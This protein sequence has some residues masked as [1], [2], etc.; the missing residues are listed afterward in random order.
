MRAP[1]RPPPEAA[2]PSRGRLISSTKEMPNVEQLAGDF[3][4]IRGDFRIAGIL[5]IGTQM[6][7]V[8]QSNG[9]FL[10]IDSYRPEEEELSAVRALTNGG[11]AIDAIVNVHPF[12]TLHCR[13]LHELF[14]RAT[15]IGTERHHREYPDLPWSKDRIEVTS[16][17]ERF[18]ADLEFAIP[19]G[20][21]FV[22][23]DE[24]VHVGSVLVRHRASRILHV[25]DTINVFTPP[26]LLRPLLP[27]PRLRFHP[28]LARA[29]GDRADAADAFEQ[30]VLGL[31]EAWADTT[32]VCA[33]HSAIHRPRSFREEMKAALAAVKPVLAL[34]RRRFA[35]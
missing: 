8:R 22:C 10:L 30:W 4:S 12:H 11:E 23:R 5:N 26:A 28:M 35:G 21:D 15:L 6:S 17:Q 2:E 34:H 29:L 27:S 1:V 13:V 24:R 7:L 33:A 19:S 3:W 14:P 9:R 25:D 16:T 18:G 32:V 20:V 31:A